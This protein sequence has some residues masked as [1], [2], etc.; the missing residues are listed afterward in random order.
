MIMFGYVLSLFASFCKR[1]FGI[2]FFNIQF[3]GF[4]LG[5]ENIKKNAET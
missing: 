3:Y 1:Y 2:I 4:G 5:E